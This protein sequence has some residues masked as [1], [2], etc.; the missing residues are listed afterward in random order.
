MNVKLVVIIIFI[1]SFHTALA[2]KN[3]I[4]VRNVTRP[5]TN[6]SNSF[7]TG[8]RKPLAALHFIKLP[9]G[10]IEPGGWILKMLELQRDGLT[11]ELGNI[12]G[13]LNKKNNAWFSGNGKGDHGWEEVPYWLKGYGDL[14]YILKDEKIIS[15]TK[16]WIEKVLQSQASDGYFGPRVV[17]NEHQQNNGNTPDLWPN[18]IMLW[19]MQSYYEYSKDARVIPFMTKYFKWEASVP[20]DKLLKLY[21]ENSRGGDNLY[22]I[23]WLYNITGDRW[24]FDLA[25]K[26]HRNTANW[27]QP[28]VNG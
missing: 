3:K 27:S 8:N 14:G 26:I 22:S 17:E 4:T 25:N 28:G 20:D 21:W 9:P 12:S 15:E 16:L 10:S 19:C 23:Y 18:M 13:W 11:G 2:Q 5:A 24:L 1:N 6:V 7:Y